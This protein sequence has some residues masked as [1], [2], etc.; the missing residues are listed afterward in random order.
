MHDAT[1]FAGDQAQ[2]LGALG[3]LETERV[4]D[5]IDLRLRGGETVGGQRL[6]LEQA[7]GIERL[8]LDGIFPPPSDPRRKRG[9]QSPE[10]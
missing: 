4:F 10:P 6:E 1:V 7:A 5:V 8:S 3:I 2:V 9:W